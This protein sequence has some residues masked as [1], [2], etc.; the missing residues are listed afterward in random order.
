MGISCY[1]HDSAIALVKD[2]QII[3]ALQE[4]RVTRIKNDS[5]FPS[6]ALEL[7]LQKNG[8]NPEEIEGV[9][10]YEKPFL[11]FERI[12]ETYH[13]FSP[14]GLSTFLKILPL[15]F[16]EKV[17]IKN[18]I[19]KELKKHKIFPKNFSFPTHHHSHMAAAFYPSPFEESAI[20]TLDGVGEWETLSFGVGK[21]KEISQWGS[22]DYPHSLGL[23]YSA[24][25]SYCGFKV[26][27][28]EYKLMGLAPYV[29]REDPKVEE[30][31]T[32]ILNH[33]I[34]IKDDGSFRLNLKYFDYMVGARMFV[35]DEWTSL[36]HLHPRSEDDPLLEEHAALAQ[37]CQLITEEVLL[38][39]ASYIQRETGLKNLCLGG[40]VALNCV[41]NGVLQ[42]A[43]IFENIWIQPASG[44]AGSALGCALASDM[45]LNSSPRSKGMKGSYLGPSYSQEEVQQALRD[46]DKKLT[47][48]GLSSDVILEQAVKDLKDG[49]VIGWF[50]GSAEFGP[51]ALGARSIL[52]DPRGKDVQQRVNFKIKKREGFRPF[53]PAIREEDFSFY[54]EGT[55]G[56]PY[57]LLV[58]PLKSSWKFKGE[59]VKGQSELPP[60]ISKQLYQVNSHFPAV[61]HVDGTSRTQV[62]NKESHPLFYW[63]LDAF[64][65]QTDCPMLL[66]TSFNVKDEPIILS[67]KDA[68]DCFLNTDLD[69]LYLENYRVTKSE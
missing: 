18:K 42:R 20:L 16:K 34:H 47:Y 60:F 69:V 58:H 31:K 26:N 50:Q 7:I 63:L 29:S 28:G 6:N 11:T 33:L 2:G 55:K 8:I 35:E 36:F 53:A 19:R 46:Y 52:A 23:F 24:F 57:M 44:D 5:S 17:F 32:L 25:T 12:L 54:F 43:N 38:K 67:P 51:R 61:V 3:T 62:V 27:N 15:W 59:S 22:I 64:K 65:N 13:A 1:Y 37:A 49:R 40:G 21:E 10:Y 14:K 56:N 39:L 48:Y 4:E 9:A 30:F 41:A 66:N 45:I 68:I